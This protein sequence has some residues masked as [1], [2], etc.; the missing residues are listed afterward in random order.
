MIIEYYRAESEETMQ[1]L[2]DKLARHL[3]KEIEARTKTRDWA[4]GKMIECDTN[5]RNEVGKRVDKKETDEEFAEYWDRKY[6]TYERA[7]KSADRDIDELQKLL[8]LT[9]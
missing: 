6:H 9:I 5:Y 2:K 7:K 8:E 4:L 3:N 1:E